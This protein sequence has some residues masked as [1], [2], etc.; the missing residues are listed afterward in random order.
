[1]DVE[2]DLGETV[3]FVCQ[4]QASTTIFWIANG[5]HLTHS[6]DLFEILEVAVLNKSSCLKEGR[7]NV[8]ALPPVDNTTIVCV[9]LSNLA[10][11]AA[12]SSPVKITVTGKEEF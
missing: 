3:S 10:L 1:M 7:L 4:A 6:T 2:A 12:L 5:E 9:A 8:Y 11:M